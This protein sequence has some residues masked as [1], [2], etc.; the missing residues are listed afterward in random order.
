MDS[1]NQEKLNGFSMCSYQHGARE[2]YPP[3][4]PLP[5]TLSS[6]DARWRV[7]LI[8]WAIRSGKRS[9]WRRTF[10]EHFNI[11][12]S[13]VMYTS[14]ISYLVRLDVLCRYSK[15][16]L[17]NISSLLS[18]CSLYV[19]RRTTHFKPSHWGAVL[20]VALYLCVSATARCC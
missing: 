20:R 17:V 3:A 9:R 5:F 13:G 19:R 2:L 12:P 10:T 18:L 15:H 6:T 8:L 16:G 4:V 1:R 11:P 7:S 14:K